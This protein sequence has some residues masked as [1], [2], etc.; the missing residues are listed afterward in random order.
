VV[1]QPW[2]RRIAGAQ[3]REEVS[4]LTTVQIA[5]KDRIIGTVSTVSGT[6]GKMRMMNMRTINVPLPGMKMMKMSMIMITRIR[7]MIR[8]AGELMAEVEKKMMTIVAIIA[9]MKGI[10]TGRRRTAI[11]IGNQT[12]IVPVTIVPEEMAVQ[13]HHV[14]T[15]HVQTHPGQNHIRAHRVGIP[16]VEEAMPRV[17][18]VTVKDIL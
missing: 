9:G 14:Q 2:I 10:T 16:M 4:I 7:I 17:S 8:T 12:E 3:N 1:L 13:T 5:M 11:M 18:D 6:I 15:H